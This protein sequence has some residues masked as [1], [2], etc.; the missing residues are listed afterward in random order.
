[1][2]VSTL[3]QVKQALFNLLVADVNLGTA[4]VQVT[5]GFPGKNPEREWVALLNGQ[6]DSEDWVNISANRKD[7]KYRM[8][9]VVNV[10]KPGGTQQEATERAM[11]LLG[12]VESI[13]RTNTNITLG[14]SGVIVAAINP[15]SLAEYPYS[16]GY[17][18][19]VEADI[20]VSARK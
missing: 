2:G 15:R 14:V 6:W 13:L 3:P 12:S 10:Q 11:E 20:Y 19:Q 17:E 16:D 18:A 1:M 5:Y 9:L 8:G 7:E 4:G